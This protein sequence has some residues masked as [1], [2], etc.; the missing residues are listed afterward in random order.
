MSTKKFWVTGIFRGTQWVLFKL[1]IIPCQTWLVN[2]IMGKRHLP[3]SLYKFLS[4]DG[5]GESLPSNE[6]I[7]G[8][9]D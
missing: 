7:E 4:L 3:R 5:R 2:G 8:E 9:G 6:A 1:G